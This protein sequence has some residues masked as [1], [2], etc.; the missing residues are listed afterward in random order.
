[1]RHHALIVT[2]SRWEDIDA[3]RKQALTMFSVPFGAITSYDFA[4]LV[5][6]IVSSV[7]NSYYSFAIF[8]DGSKEDWSVSEV[9][10]HLRAQFKDW[11]RSQAYEDLS[12]PY[13]WV[14][15]QYGDDEW[16][17]KVTD[18]NDAPRRARQG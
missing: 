18:D 5:A 2:A 13:A 7:E 3:A 6:P 1:M 14:E 10:D 8:P 16:E 17:T 15:V 12:S 4:A 9:G 11:L